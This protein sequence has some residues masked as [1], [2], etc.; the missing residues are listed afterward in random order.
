MKSSEPQGIESGESPSPLLIRTE[1]QT[2]LGPMIAGATDSGLCLLEFHDRRALP[3]EIEELSTLLACPWADLTSPQVSSSVA[4]AAHLQ[5]IA[6][7]LA[8]Y[9]A[10][11]LRDFTVPLLTPGTPFELRVWAALKAIPYGT[12]TAYGRLATSLGQPGGARAVGRANGRNRIAIVIPCHRVINEDGT[13]R[14]YG[15]GLE[16]KRFLLDLEHAATGSP[17]TLFSAT[18]AAA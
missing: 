9:F 15:G 16:R 8:R 6:A 11:E 18:H 5:T 14:G 12:T 1:L 2:P 4:A 3:G 17:G 10:G 13:L 7:E